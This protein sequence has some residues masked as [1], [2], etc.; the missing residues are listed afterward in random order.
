MRIA[1]T[2]KQ[3]REC[4]KILHREGRQTNRINPHSRFAELQRQPRV[5]GRAFEPLYNLE[6]PP[7]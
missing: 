3:A 4:P 6:R 1:Q 7:N 5:D 2:L